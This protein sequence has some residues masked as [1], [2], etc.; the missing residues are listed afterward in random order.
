MRAF[1]I[2]AVLAVAA[3][4]G[5]VAQEAPQRTLPR[6]TGGNEVGVGEMLLV[7]SPPA[8]TGGERRSIRV[9]VWYPAVTGTG[10]PARYLARPEALAGLASP[11]FIRAA[12]EVG[13]H[14][15][16]GATPLKEGAP[17]PLVLISHSLGGL[18]ELYTGLA[19]EL[20]S[21]GYLVGAVGHPGG[22]LAVAME[23]SVIPFSEA[24]DRND[25]SVVG[26][27]SALA[28]RE[29]RVKVWVRDVIRV[30]TVMPVLELDVAGELLRAMVDTSRVAYLG[31]SIGGSAA[32]LG[33]SSSPIFDACVN[34]DGWPLPPAAERGFDQPYLHVEET[35][36]YRSAAQLEEW[37]ATRPEYDG[38]MWALEA[39]KDSIFQA[40]GGAYHL[41]VDGLSHQ[42]FSDLPLW[43][44][45]ERE[46]QPLAPE[47]GL[48]ILRDW[49]RWFLDRH[50]RGDVDARPPDPVRFPEIHFT[51]YGSSWSQDRPGPQQ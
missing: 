22:A 8:D 23:D 42:G 13:S 14:A 12:G 30:A 33:C 43:Y 9:R 31:H 26:I 24:W 38:N 34:L 20:A 48:A 40:M 46:A 41:V 27:D 5:A 36:P 50:V 6:P 17:Y 29:Q 19:E 21:H 1:A 51:A 25:P 47:R 49:V 44:D 35:R 32:A 7:N 15:R 18:P 16:D 28:F 3:G 2:V 45:P 39:R 37:G 10:S 4:T 11:A